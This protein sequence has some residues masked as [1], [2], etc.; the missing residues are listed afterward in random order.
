MAD[1]SPELTQ[2]FNTSLE[3]LMEPVRPRLEQLVDQDL[4]KIDPVPEQ[5]RNLEK[6]TDLV[7]TT[8]RQAWR[9]WNSAT[10]AERRNRDPAKK[11]K[12]KSN[13]KA[14]WES[15]LAS[16]TKV[17]EQL[18]SC[19]ELGKLCLDKRRFYFAGKCQRCA[20]SCYTITAAWQD[21][22]SEILDLAASQT[23]KKAV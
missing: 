13:E 23:T 7:L 15:F 5:V 10:K 16:V 8:S 6:V 21:Y 12:L 14:S 1:L 17:E 22:K 18:A 2:A 19:I 20:E 3:Q 9:S 4:A 11:R